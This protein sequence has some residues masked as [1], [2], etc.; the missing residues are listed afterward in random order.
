MI[1]KLCLKLFA[2]VLMICCGGGGLLPFVRD[3]SSG[4]H[5]HYNFLLFLFAAGA[6]ALLVAGFVVV[7]FT[8]QGLSARKWA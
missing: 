6:F 7:G 8:V 1:G 5:I 4:T 2:G 3:L